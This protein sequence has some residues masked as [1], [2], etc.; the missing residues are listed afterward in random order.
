MGLWNY[1]GLDFKLLLA[2]I[3]H[4]ALCLQASFTSVKSP[5]QS[6]TVLRI[7]GKH[8]VNDSYYSCSF[9]T[10]V[11]D[12][13]SGLFPSWGSLSEGI[14]SWDNMGIEEI[15]QEYKNY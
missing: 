8:E 12:K 9:H 3:S 4:I 6:G 10:H 1:K 14:F 7:Q 13:D 11:L 15:I 5:L 2:Y